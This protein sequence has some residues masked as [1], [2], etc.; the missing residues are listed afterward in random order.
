M[1]QS[2]RLLI[3]T[4]TLFIAGDQDHLGDKT[5][6][7]LE[8]VPNF[9]SRV[10]VLSSAVMTRF[11][12]ASRGVLRCQWEEFYFFAKVNGGY[13]IGRQRDH[14]EI[15]TD[16]KPQRSLIRLGKYRNL[17]GLCYSSSRSEAARKILLK[18]CATQVF[19]PCRFDRRTEYILT[20]VH[21]PSIISLP[22]H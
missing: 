20:S 4:Q 1:L 8:G 15:K 19:L 14:V 22:R 12:W 5:I 6:L 7:G 16:T 11:F 9:P 18:G 13:R 10:Y 17:H 2:E 3:T 21:A